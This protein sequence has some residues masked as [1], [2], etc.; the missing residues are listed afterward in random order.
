MIDIFSKL[1]EDIRLRGFSD[2]TREAYLGNV[3]RY[4]A[5]LGD[6]PLEATS[7]ADIRRYS[8]YLRDE[9]HLAPKTIN[10]YLAA[11]V[12]L[13][14]VTLGR[15]LNKKQVP[16]MRLSRKLPQL[17]SRS[18][19]RALMEETT[20][21]KH[22]AIFSLGYGSGLRVSEVCHLK[23]SD[24]DSK[25]MRLFIRS[26]KGDKDRYTV[27]SHTSLRYLREYW[28]MYRPNHPEGWL[29]PGMRNIGTI[30]KDGCNHAFKSA[31][32]R[33]GIDPEGRSYHLLRHCF[34][35]YMLEDGIDPATL[36]ELL[37]HASLSSTALYLHLANV[38]KGL[39]CSIDRGYA[40]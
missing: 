17:L 30:T 35:T 14:D 40:S 27:L 31:L 25:R 19:L 1:D 37:G 22:C 13:Y 29:F 16:R 15:E 9:R 28:K 33:I 3:K 10:T 23:V 32:R 26:G 18:E 20:N 7:E 39:C 36:K 11:V 8:T 4:L 21:L 6:L 12:F 2:K 5:F 38:S 34:A 24:I